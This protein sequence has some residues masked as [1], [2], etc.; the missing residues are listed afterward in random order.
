MAD[1]TESLKTEDGI[2]SQI[3]SNPSELKAQDS[4]PNHVCIS[5]LQCSVNYQAL[6]NTKSKK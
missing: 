1:S 6:C 2:Y 5:M 3:H 4:A